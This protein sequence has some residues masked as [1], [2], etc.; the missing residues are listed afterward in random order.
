M[1]REARAR[2]AELVGPDLFKATLTLVLGIA[3]FA[4]NGFLVSTAMPSAVGDIG[5]LAW[6]SWTVTLFFVLSIVGGALAATLKARWGAGRVLLVAAAAHGLGTLLSAVA[7][8]MAVMLLGRA[9]QGLGEGVIAALCYALI[10]ALYPP[11]L[12]PKVFGVESMV[13]AS[14]ACAGP[15]VAGVLTQVWS[16]RLAFLVNLP[17]T[18]LFMALVPRVTAGLARSADEPGGNGGGAA[19]PWVRLAAVGGGILLVSLASVAPSPILSWLALG[20][21]LAVLAA[22]LWRDRHARVRLF[23]RD[24]FALLAPPPPGAAGRTVPAGIWSILLMNMAM[25]GGSVYVA[26]TAQTLWH[27]RPVWVGALAAGL[28]VSWSTTAILVATLGLGTAGGVRGAAAR[29]RMIRIGPALVAL[30]LLAVAYGFSHAVPALVALGQLSM[31][32]GCGLGWGFLCQAVMDAAPPQERDHASALL[33]TVQSAGFG[34][35]AALAGL[36]GNAAGYA[37]PG[38]DM[39]WAAACVFLAGTVTAVAAQAVIWAVRITPEA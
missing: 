37:A 16:W 5:G 29:R 17:A 20:V 7:P 13:W 4:F 1:E 11:A 12:V 6:V 22:S 9:F 18:V 3:L 14:A 36:I 32:F 35:G 26:L 21:A 38:G 30:G 27:F 2:W 19:P 31:G 25:A 24:A 15:L 39:G 23:P 8:N 28:A 34:V 33:P 10:P